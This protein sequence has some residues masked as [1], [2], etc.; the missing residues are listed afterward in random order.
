MKKALIFVLISICCIMFVG[1]E[2][3]DHTGEAKTPSGSS[4]MKGRDFQSVADSFEEKGFT[5][6]KFEKIEDLI[7]G[8]LTKDGEVEQVSVGGDV[9]YSPDKWIAADTEVIISYHTFSENETEQKEGSTEAPKQTTEQ[10]EGEIILTIENSE[11]LAAVLSTKNEFD[12]IIKNFSEKYAGRTIEFDGNVAY[13]NKHENY[14][15]RFDILIGAGDYNEN[16]AVGPNFQFNDVGVYDLDLDTL[17]LEDVISIGKNLHIV[18]KIMKYNENSGLFELDPV[19][20]KV[21]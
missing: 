6:I 15:T 21:R 11:E 3:G 9:D 8:F 5:S 18:A 12:P 1:C 17:Y 14:D 7:T 20:V 2:D 16:T 10:T 4:V 19:A 13:L